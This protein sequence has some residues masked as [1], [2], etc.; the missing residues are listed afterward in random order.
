MGEEQIK[1]RLGPDVFAVPTGFILTRSKV[2]VKRL[3]YGLYR[4]DE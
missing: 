3:N 1:D 4:L 2:L